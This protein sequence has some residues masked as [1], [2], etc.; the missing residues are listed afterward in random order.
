MMK[1]RKNNLIKH[2]LRDP[3]TGFPRR[4]TPVRLV[5]LLLNQLSR[6][7]LRSTF[8]LGYPVHC[9]IEANNTCDLK[10]PM[11][12]SGSEYST[13]KRGHMSFENF[14]KIIDELGPYLYK[15]GPFNLGEPLLHKDIFRM[16]DYAQQNNISTILSTNANSLT[17][18][19]AEKL[20]DSGLEE[21]I[22]SLDAA[23]EE[24]Y[25]INRTGGDFA[26]VKSNIKELMAVRT[27]KKSRFPYVVINMVLMKNNIKEMEEFKKLAEELGVDNYNF[28]TYWEMYLGDSEKEK[29][30]SAF[31][32]D[33]KEFRNIMPE[34][35]RVDKTCGWAWSG[36][37]IGWNG[38]L[39]PCC[40]DYNETYVIGNVFEGGVKKLWNSAKYRRLRKFIVEGRKAP[41]VCNKCPRV[42]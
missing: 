13:R 36:C 29:L 5:N 15:V 20:V 9:S 21:L 11:C 25:N 22:V 19:R 34:N 28:S 12:S 16:I 23:T 41:K 1:R 37:V 7:L 8:V 38:S 30:T 14:K 26:R 2:F 33:V 10:C 39:T 18:E 40:F 35:M 42:F 31:V 17:G 24:T 27:E 32:P 3:V 6:K 4:H